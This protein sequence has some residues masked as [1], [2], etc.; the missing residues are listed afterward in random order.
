MGAINSDR[1]THRTTIEG[2]GAKCKVEQNIPAAAT[3]SYGRL[4][5]HPRLAGDQ[6]MIEFFGLLIPPV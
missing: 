5:F 4:T 3:K 6:R 1:A 2:T